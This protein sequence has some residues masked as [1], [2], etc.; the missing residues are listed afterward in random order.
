MQCARHVAAVGDIR[1]AYK[2][3]IGKIKGKDQIR[4]PRLRWENNMKMMLRK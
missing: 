4:R 3:Y 2:G 1:N